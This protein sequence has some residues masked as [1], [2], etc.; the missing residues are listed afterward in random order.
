MKEREEEQE[1]K[2]R[3][4]GEEVWQSSEGESDVRSCVLILTEAVDSPVL[5]PGGD[6]SLTSNVCEWVCIP[7]PPLYNFVTL[8][9]SD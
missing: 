7:F 2:W 6:S 4:E 8:M 3:R 5:S 9:K 1:D